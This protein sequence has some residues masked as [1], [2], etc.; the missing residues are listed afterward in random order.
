M[1]RHDANFPWRVVT[2][3]AMLL[4][5]LVLIG[6][7]FFFSLGSND[8]AVS[9]T[10]DDATEVAPVPPATAAT[11]V[12]TVQP[13]VGDPSSLESLAGPTTF[14]LTDA[15][16]VD[17]LSIARAEAG[18]MDL[19][20]FLIV[21]GLERLIP[22]LHT[23]AAP[24]TIDLQVRSAVD[25]LISWSG[26][27]TISPVPPESR[28]REIWVAQSGVAY[29]DFYQSFFD[30]SGGGSLNELHTVYSIVA[31]L[32]ESFPEIF[33]VQ[34]LVEG[35]QLETLAGHVDLSHPLQP[36]ADWV[37]IEQEGGTDQQPQDPGGIDG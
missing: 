18:T 22:V 11:S 26:D 27:E 30:F 36:S 9:A 24:P 35:E 29:I 12:P 4:S 13:T 16:T 3:S 34:F 5:V 14:D 37:L 8:S 25:E 17:G 20:L 33:A 10:N 1:S 19:R 7:V 2:I 6:W 28:V 32:T 23:V 21:S 31:T 15:E